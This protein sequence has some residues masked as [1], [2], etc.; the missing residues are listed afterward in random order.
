[1][2]AFCDDE[3]SDSAQC[4]SDSA[5]RPALLLPV[6]R[7]E[8][9]AQDEL[10]AA[11]RADRLL[12]LLGRARARVA[13]LAAQARRRQRRPAPDPG[14]AAQGAQGPDDRG[15]LPLSRISRRRPHFGPASKEGLARRRCGSPMFLAIFAGVRTLD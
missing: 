9:V 12:V 15:V 1:M 11:R 13:L 6:L 3:V 14:R 2:L 10:Q 8:E 5:P 4:A 7:A